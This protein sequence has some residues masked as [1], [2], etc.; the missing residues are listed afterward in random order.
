MKLQ[1]LRLFGW[2]VD[3]DVLILADGEDVDLIK[4]GDPSYQDMRKSTEAQR[5]QLGLDY[6]AGDHTKVITSAKG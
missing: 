6:V 5:K 3:V 2:F 1:Q 4:A